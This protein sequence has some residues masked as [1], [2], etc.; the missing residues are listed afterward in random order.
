MKERRAEINNFFLLKTLKW[1]FFCIL[2]IAI[3]PAYVWSPHYWCHFKQ[4]LKN[5]SRAD[6]QVSFI[7]LYPLLFPVEFVGSRIYVQWFFQKHGPSKAAAIFFFFDLIVVDNLFLKQTWK[8]QYALAGGKK[9]MMK[10][11]I[12]FCVYY[13]LLYTLQAITDAT[14]LPRPYRLEHCFHR[15]L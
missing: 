9:M 2:F 13:Q 12:S 5:L 8:Q 6:P 4:S 14:N 11:S 1:T 10:Q 7:L 15:H 3:L